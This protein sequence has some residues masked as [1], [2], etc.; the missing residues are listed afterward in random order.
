MFSWFRPPNRGRSIRTPGK[1]DAVSIKIEPKTIEL[2]L[3]ELGWFAE[4]DRFPFL[5]VFHTHPVCVGTTAAFGPVLVFA[6]HL[7][8]TR[9]MRARGWMRF[10]GLTENRAGCW[11]WFVVPPEER[12]RSRLAGVSRV[13]RD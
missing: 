2:S 11:W 6:W 5:L 4:P 3:V 7:G 9:L 12:L 8:C 1:V 13:V 10:G